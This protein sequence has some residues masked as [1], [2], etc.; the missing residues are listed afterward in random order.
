MKIALLQMN[1]G[2]DPAVNAAVVVSAV[3]DAV[4]QGAEVLFTPEMSNM[5]DRDRKRA[6]EKIA[7]EEDDVFL[8]E[9][10]KAARQHGISVHIGSLAV[11][12][13]DGKWRNRSIL[14]DNTG[15]V[16]AHY[17]KIHLFD[18]ELGGGDNWRES[19]VYKAGAHVVLSDIAGQRLGFSICYD[20]RFPALYRKLA[21]AKA[22]IIAIPAAFTVPTGEAHWHV[23][24]RA[25][26]IETS[27]FVIA[28]A[29]CG[30]HEDGRK[31]YGHSLVVDPWGRVLHDGG[32]EPGLAVVELDMEQIEKVRQRLP[33]LANARE[34]EDYT[35][36]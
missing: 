4:G 19:S 15:K 33:S 18:V 23:L 28:A 31:T 21:E 2:I 8:A 27:S 29:Q 34:I 30:M 12:H 36:S 25:R 5:L 7:C 9:V 24:L 13:G 17:D 35:V 6:A 1:G 22:D 16:R 3:A 20:I 10:R 26:A 14:I 11:D 32:Q